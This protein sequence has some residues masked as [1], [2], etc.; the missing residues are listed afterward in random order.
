M[1]RAMLEVA[2]IGLGSRV[3]I[4]GAAQSGK[5][6]LLRRLAIALAATDHIHLWLVLAGVRPEEL[7]EWRAGPVEPAAA[8][9][10]SASGE[11]QG[12]AVE[13]VVEQARRM[14]ARGSDAVVLIDSL[15]ALAPHVARRLL[16]AARKLADAGSLTVIG[17]RSAP[18][19]GETTV[20]GL[21]AA[22]AR[23]GRFPSLDPETS[24]TMR[25]ELLRG[26]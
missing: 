18:L 12:Q 5:S 9:A 1:V 22:L 3:T 16:G 10:L 11:A 14:A 21:D 23:A 20:V 13:A 4:C 6:E 25:A 26:G 8:L 24:W 2:P 7:S 15:E 17:T 19:G